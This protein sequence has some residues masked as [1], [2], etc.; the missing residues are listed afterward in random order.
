[1]QALTFAEQRGKVTVKMLYYH[2]IKLDVSINAKVLQ[3]FLPK[4]YVLLSTPSEYMLVCGRNPRYLHLF[5]D[6]ILYTSST[7]V[8]C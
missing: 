2:H 7:V 5:F 3:L 4:H 1:M 6:L 8:T